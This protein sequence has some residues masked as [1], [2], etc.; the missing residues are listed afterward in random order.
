MKQGDVTRTT[1]RQV[2]AA[3]G[4]SIATVSRVLNGRGNVAP[5]TRELV[6]NAVAR[7][8]GPGPQPRG[9]ARP[10]SGPVVPAVGPAPRT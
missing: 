9:A 2:A 5:E 1:V 7:L 10:V 4:V 6:E 8:D 3:A